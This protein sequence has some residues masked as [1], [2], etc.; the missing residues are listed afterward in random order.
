MNEKNKNIVKNSQYAQNTTNNSVLQYLN[1]TGFAHRTF[2]C[3][4]CKSTAFKI[5]KNI[6][7]WF[8]EAMLFDIRKAD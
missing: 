7:P 6:S 1:Y 2:S 5:R 8:V 3:N 4:Y